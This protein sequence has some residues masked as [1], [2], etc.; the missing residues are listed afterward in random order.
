MGLNNKIRKV[1]SIVVRAKNK[2]TSVIEKIN[3]HL[4]NIFLTKKI[5]ISASELFFQHN[6]VND[7]NRYDMIVRLLAVE[8]YYG[9]NNYGFDLYLRMQGVR[10]ACKKAQK[11][12][13]RFKSLIESY[14]KN[15]YD[16]NSRIELDKNLHLIDGSHRLA[17]AMYHNIPV[18]TAKVRSYSLDVYYSIEWFKVNDFTDEECDILKAKYIELYNKHLQPFVCTLWHPVRKYYDEITAK[19]ALFGKVLE[20]KDV[21]V[22]KYD[23]AYLTRGIYSVDDIEKWKIEKKIEHMVSDTEETYNLRMVTL[24]LEEPKFRLKATTNGTL[25]AT[26]E[27]VKKIIRDAYKKRVDNYFHDIV[28]H[29]GDNFFQNRHIYRLLTMPT[30]DMT[31]IFDNIS[32]YKYV[33]TKMNVDYMPSKFPQQYPLGK[34]VDVL[35]ADKDNFENIV[36]SIWNDVQKLFDS[37]LFDLRV[38]ERSKTRKQIRIEQDGYPVFIFDC[39]FTLENSEL[40][41]PSLICENRTRKENYYIPTTEYEIL[42]RL[43]DFKSHP[44]KTK[45]IEYVKGNKDSINSD[46]LNKQLKFNWHKLIN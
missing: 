29:I 30:I 42:A 18:I 6:G 1:Q 3:R 8:E 5:A 34:D 28:M 35:C 27:L 21:I 26:C 19:L 12:A 46:L 20:A 25:S 10:S 37:S 2:L 31:T 17:L 38:W 13:E 44:E 40:N 36:V 24:K 15:G 4:S 16:H 7:F 22:T 45:H 11:G 23:Y 9:K 32:N 43:C 14:E 33:L 39:S 41:T